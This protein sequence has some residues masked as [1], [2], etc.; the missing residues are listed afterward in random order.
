MCSLYFTFYILFTYTPLLKCITSWK[1]HRAPNGIDRNKDAEKTLRYLKVKKHEAT[2]Y[3]M[4]G[5][6]NVII[7]SSANN[8]K[9]LIKYP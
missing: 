4:C 5:K 2:R 9:I 6:N 1:Y 8:Y 3:L 7:L